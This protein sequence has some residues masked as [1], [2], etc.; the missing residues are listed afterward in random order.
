[1]FYILPFL[2]IVNNFSTTKSYLN[3]KVTVMNV[4]FGK[5]LICVCF[6]LKALMQASANGNILKFRSLLKIFYSLL[7]FLNFYG[8]GFGF[9]AKLSG[10]RSYLSLEKSH[11]PS[12]SYI[13]LALKTASKIQVFRY[14]DL[15]LI[16]ATK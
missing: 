16:A 7:H 2:I 11:S 8:P 9:Q 10:V 5:S 13:Q 12:D 15:L 3:K 1:M 4:S 6:V 14:S